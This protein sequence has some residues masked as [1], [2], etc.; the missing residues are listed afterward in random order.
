MLYSVVDKLFLATFRTGRE[1]QIGLQERGP[2]CDPQAPIGQ[3]FRIVA[4]RGVSSPASQ[5]RL[6]TEPVSP[7][8]AI[9]SIRRRQPIMAD[10]PP[11]PAPQISSAESDGVLR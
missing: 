4:G 7:H 6:T 10:V 1:W 11:V 2:F 3:P 5:K 9:S 8:R